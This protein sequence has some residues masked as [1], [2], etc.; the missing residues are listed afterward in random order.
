MQHRKHSL[1][2]DLQ[3]TPACII[4]SSIMLRHRARVNCARSIATVVR[5]RYLDTSSIVTCG[6]HLA[7]ADVYRVTSQQQVYT[8]Q[9]V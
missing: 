1:G 3:K 8:P 9:Y 4:T 7:T 6:H 5:V 2:A